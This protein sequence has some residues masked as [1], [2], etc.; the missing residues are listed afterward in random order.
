MISCA[1]IRTA[2]ERRTSLTG[3]YNN[4]LRHF[5]PHALGDDRFGNKIVVAF[6]YD[7]RQM[8]GLPE[9][10]EWHL[11]QLDRLDGVTRNGDQ[12]VTGPNDALKWMIGL[13]RSLDLAA[14]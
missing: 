4:Y 1:T 3:R 11:F 8:V 6:Q 7:G 14:E 10:G 9:R 12:W 5:S 2:I 13:L